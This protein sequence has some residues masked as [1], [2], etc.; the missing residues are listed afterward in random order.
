[1]VRVDPGLL[2]PI[3]HRPAAAQ[4]DLAVIRVR[5]Q[6][7]KVRTQLVNTARGVVKS[8]GARL[9][10]ADAAHFAKTWA[11]VPESLRP[12]LDPLYRALG[13]L[14]AQIDALDEQAATLSKERY[15]ETERLRSVPGIGPVTALCYVLTLGDP[16]RFRRRRD[17]GAY[18]GLRPKQRQS[19]GR[20]PELGIAKNGD[21]YLRT[22]LVECAHHVLS[23]G[24]DSALKQW[25]LKLANGGKGVKKR[26]LV[27]V[28]RKLAV[29]L[30]RLWTTGQ[31]FHPFPEQ[32]VD[33]AER[34]H[35]SLGTA[36]AT[37]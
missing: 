33:A 3:T 15:P 13:P 7:V 27:A 4:S 32:T 17:A 14:N 10:A 25:G 31:R 28:A 29:L 22:L 35:R 21:S 34:A 8:L 19:R 5:A 20:D 26:A 12:A 2:F 37:A 6:W 16:A 9:P 24:P 18:L 30:H 36:A 11:A 23:R 1:M